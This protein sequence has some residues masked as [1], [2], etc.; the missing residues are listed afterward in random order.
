M[1]PI[2]IRTTALAL[3]EKLNV[4]SSTNPAAQSLQR[5]LR[6]YINAA[7]AGTLSAPVAL[8][9]IPGEY[10]FIDGPLGEYRDLEAA[11]SSFKLEIAGKREVTAKIMKGFS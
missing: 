3:Q 7:L 10:L 9:D 1:D 4:Y 8:G 5:A 11:Y 2:A 6:G